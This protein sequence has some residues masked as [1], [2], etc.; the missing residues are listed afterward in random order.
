M[1]TDEQPVGISVAQAQGIADAFMKA[2]KGNISLKVIVGNMQEDIYGPE[3]VTGNVGR[4]KDA[5][6]PARG[7]FTLASRNLSSVGDTIDI[8]RHEVL[9][10]YGLNTLAPVD[11]RRILGQ[12]V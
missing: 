6:H 7:V 12:L 9:G 11:K 3:A 8:I 5:Y 2:Y 1:A 10:H 4:I